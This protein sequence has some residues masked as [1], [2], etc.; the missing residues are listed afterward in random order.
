MRQP[1]T[2]T[3]TDMR[4]INRSA[5]LELIRRESPISRT[6]IA[7]RLN[8]SLP[9]VMRIV[10]ELAEEDLVRPHGTKEWSGGRRR[11]LL[12]F[13]ADGHVVVGVDLGGTKMFGAIANL[14]GEILDEN[15]V[16]RHGTSGEKS[17]ERLVEMI[18]SLLH[19]PKIEG[20]RILGIG[21]GVPGITLHE[22]GI[23][24]WAPS[25]NWRDYPLR[26]K[27]SERFPLPVMVDNDV[28][29]A[30]LGELWFGAAQNTQNMV[31]IAIGTGIGAGIIV[32]GS[33]YRGFHEAAGEVGYLLPGRD[34]LG[35]RYDGF[36]ALEG[37]ASGAGIAELARRALKDQRPP[38]ALAALVAEDVFDAARHGEP[39][40]K[41]VIDTA[42]D[43]LAIM[44][45]G[46]TAFLDPELIVLGGGV[47]RSA[48]LLLDP[49]L[50]RVEGTIPDLPRLVA[51]TLG[52]RATVLGAITN[53]L[54][55]TANFY[56]VHKLS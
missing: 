48:D 7:E 34:F 11:S 26:T 4:G 51:S 1:Y 56:V 37:V 3:A 22:K 43:Y 30:A 15:E 20:R 19:S 21:V 40:A 36:G 9:T 24:V 23:V 54:H 25:L 46:I 18:E 49:I 5:I 10:D 45:G 38:E 55:N 52:H 32:D 6:L 17:Y 53:V 27:L 2:I 50:R 13:N 16:P 44:V 8:V 39:W 42:I 28:N 33:L 41:A 12:E 35:K 47:A 29:L 14:G 31:L